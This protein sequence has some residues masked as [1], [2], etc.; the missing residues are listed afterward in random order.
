MTRLPFLLAL[1]L[2][3]VLAAELWQAPAVPS[4]PAPVSQAPAQPG[5]APVPTV[6]RTRD[7]A[8]TLLARP[9]FTPGR[10]PPRDAA[11]AVAE[12]SSADL[13]RLAG[14]LV[15]G[16]SRRAILVPA[17]GSKPTVVP[18][19]AQVGA[20]AVERIE[21]GQV[22]L[23]G[24]A[25]TRVLRPTFDPLPPVAKPVAGPVPGLSGLIGLPAPP[26]ARAAR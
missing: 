15:N 16:A 3:G 19:G 12:A 5:A 8:A 2:A 14:V 26:A 9:L 20:F 11:E 10:R 6:E 1:V 13:P 21:P 18:E 7:S 22:T 4:L 24:P 25:G 17:P 23:V